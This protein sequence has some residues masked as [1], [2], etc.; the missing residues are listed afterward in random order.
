M[1]HEMIK[2]QLLIAAHQSPSTSPRIVTEYLI[3][4]EADLQIQLN[5][6]PF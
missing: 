4:K 2:N 1:L 5:P 3:M 6:F